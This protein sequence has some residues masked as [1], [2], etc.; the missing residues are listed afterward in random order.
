MDTAVISYFQQL[1]SRNCLGQGY[2]LLGDNQALTGQLIRELG[3]SHDKACGDCWDCRQFTAFTHPDLIVVEA[4]GVFIKIEQIRESMKFLAMKSFC[5]PRKILLIKNAQNLNINAAN[6]FLKTLEE[7]P[8]NSIILMSAV[9]MEGILPTIVSRCRKI[10]MP[11]EKDTAMTIDPDTL[12]DFLAGE[13]I[14][15]SE[16]KYFLLFLQAFSELLRLR[17]NRS[18]GLNNQLPVPNDCEIILPSWDTDK[19]M[20]ILEKTLIMQG[21]YNSVNEN[22]ALNIIRMEML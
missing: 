22:L 11:P 18:V 19:I 21:V 5:A 12:K 6:A 15:F 3:C 10:F 1:K 13:K 8:D 2:L 14:K 9:S 20:R 7:P 17:L 16:R 4:E